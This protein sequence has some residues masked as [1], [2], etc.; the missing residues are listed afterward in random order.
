MAQI[1]ERNGTECP[2][3]HNGLVSTLDYSRDTTANVLLHTFMTGNLIL[4]ECEAGERMRAGLMKRAN[5]PDD[6]VTQ[7]VAVAEAVKRRKEKLFKEASV[8]PRFSSFTFNGYVAQAKGDPGKQKMIETILAH[9]KGT[10]EKLGIMLCGPTGLGKTGAL[11]PLFLHYM[12]KGY[13][14]LWLPYFDMMAGFKDFESGQVSAKIALA[15]DVNLLFIDDMGDPKRQAATDYEREVVFRLVDHR[16]NYGLPM[17]ITSNL[18]LDMLDGYYRPEL[19][20]RLYE[21]CDV[22]PVTGK[23]IGG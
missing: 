8:P 14:G 20:K 1:R 5:A 3:C 4:C 6:A 10:N 19:V 18:S 23:R 11:S 17:F 2:M 16:N 12:D 9:Y 7:Q 15:Q 13:S 21:A 22:V